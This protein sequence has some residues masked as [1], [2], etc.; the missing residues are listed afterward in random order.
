MRVLGGLALAI[1]GAAAWLAA[2]GHRDP[3]T[4]PAALTEE[5]TRVKGALGEAVSA[6]RRAARDEE[7][8]FERE[9]ADAEAR[10]NRLE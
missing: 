8:A 7:I 10:R 2:R 5:A 4:W 6:G 9:L 1:A 3:R